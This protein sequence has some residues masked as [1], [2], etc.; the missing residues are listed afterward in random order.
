MRLDAG[1]P[2]VYL[3]K[4][5]LWPHMREFSDRSLEHVRA[6]LEHL[7]AAHAPRPVR[8]LCVHGHYAEGAEA[9]CSI[10]ASLGCPAVVTGHSLGR[11][12]LASS[13][14]FCPTSP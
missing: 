9:A 8:L 11:S 1:N 2:A 12:K 14:S 3:R 5:L 13:A 7:K 4:E 10:A 6:T